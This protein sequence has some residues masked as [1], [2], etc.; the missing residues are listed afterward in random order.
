M[1]FELDDYHRNTPDEVLLSDLIDVAKKL[2]KKTVTMNEYDE[3]GKFHSNTIALRFKSWLAALQLAGLDK[4]RNYRTSEEDYFKNIEELWIKL[5]CQPKRSDM[6]RPLSRFHGTA[7]EYRFGTWRKALEK[8]V[9]YINQEPDTFP[10]SENATPKP[11]NPS[12]K[13]KTSRT[14][15]WRLRFII[16]RRDNFRCKKCGKSPATDQTITLH[17]DHI[18]PWSKGGETVPDNL[19]T[20]CSVCNIGKSNLEDH[21]INSE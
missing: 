16:M 13:Q 6:I 7:Y 2:G 5:G 14:I 3:M 11:E 15:S 12:K 18:N 8:F 17:V 19:Q 9:E 10:V 20:L 1:K 4:T 21:N